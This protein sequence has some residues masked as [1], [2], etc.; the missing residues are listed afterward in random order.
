MRTWARP[1]K[2]P[3]PPGEP[4]ARKRLGRRA[5]HVLFCVLGHLRRQRI[6]DADLEF[7]GLLRGYEAYERRANSNSACA[8]GGYGGDNCKDDL[9]CVAYIH[10]P[11]QNML[12]A[13][14]H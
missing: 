11:G 8:T 14:A 5:G 3:P 2:R 9:E 1:S 13:E 12:Q 10:S 6:I 4:P 7:N